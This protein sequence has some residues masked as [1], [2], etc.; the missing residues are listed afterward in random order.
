[1]NMLIR[2]TIT[3]PASLFEQMREA[4]Y[5][6]KTTI[7]GLMRDTMQKSLKAQTVSGTLAKLQGTYAVGGKRAVVSRKDLYETHL[8]KKVSA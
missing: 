8:R 1:M 3:I 5:Q 4:A 7:S 6:R 2:T